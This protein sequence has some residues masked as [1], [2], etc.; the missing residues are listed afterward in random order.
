MTPILIIYFIIH[1]FISS[2]VNW[3]MDIS[4][5]KHTSPEDE[6]TPLTITFISH[7]FAPAFLLITILQNG[8]KVLGKSRCIFTGDKL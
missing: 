4:N 5:K 6:V 7:L 1:L 3:R 2:Y 8:F